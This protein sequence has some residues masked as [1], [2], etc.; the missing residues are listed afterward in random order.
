M[1]TLKADIYR[2]YKGKLGVISLIFLA[3]IGVFFTLISKEKN[4]F[5]ALKGVLQFGNTLLPIFLTN[6]F[7]IVWGNE[8]TYRTINNVLVT[9]KKRASIFTVKYLLALMLTVV[10]ALVFMT[11]A[12]IAIYFKVGSFQVI[13]VLKIFAVQ[14]PIYFAITSFG[15]LIFILI[16]TT[17]VAVAVFVSLAMIGDNFISTLISSYLSNWEKLI[18]TLFF[19][20]L[21][22]VV[23]LKEIPEETLRII[24]TSGIIYGIIGFIIAYSLFNTKEFK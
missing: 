17:Y 16:P 11:S 2:I 1:S 24:I 10:F 22:I 12:S 7:M 8:F 9:G 13:D 14:L 23:N 19:K 3:L 18:D 5:E 21:Q 6:I 15:V 4:A 20:N